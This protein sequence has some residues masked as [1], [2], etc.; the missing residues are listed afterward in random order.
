M[1]LAVRVDWMGGRP[2]RTVTL[3]CLTD[4]HTDEGFAY[5]PVGRAFRS[6]EAVEHREREYVFGRVAD[7]G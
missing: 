2:H 5:G 3:K 6:H 4:L 1:L 7:R